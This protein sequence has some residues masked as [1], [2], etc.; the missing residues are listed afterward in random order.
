MQS[1][2][3]ILDSWYFTTS[4]ISHRI[5][6]ECFV[7]VCLKIQRS[8]LEQDLRS[9]LFRVSVMTSFSVAGHCDV[10]GRE[11][12]L[13]LTLPTTP[14]TEVKMCRPSPEDL[15]L[16]VNEGSIFVHPIRQ[17]MDR[18]ALHNALGNASQRMARLPGAS[19]G[20]WSQEAQARLRP[21]SRM[22]PPAHLRHSESPSHSPWPKRSAQ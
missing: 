6:L 11:A 14:E 18:K 12:I 19:R 20:G 22:N 5:L 13:R 8:N 17:P 16:K 10:Q 15:M 2:F 21:P 1:R 7:R 9:Y 4:L 3:L